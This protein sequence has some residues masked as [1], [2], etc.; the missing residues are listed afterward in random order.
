MQV[1]EGVS[2][3]HLTLRANPVAIRGFVKAI[4][5]STSLTSLDLCRCKLEDDVA[6]ALA[7]TLSGRNTTLLT[8]DLTDNFL[9]SVAAK[10]FGEMLQGNT[11][12]RSLSLEQVRVGQSA[13]V[14]EG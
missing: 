6:V 4:P 8:V 5:A 7:G 9:T 11:S 2:P 13:Q 1:D 3:P 14:W 10:A 12:L